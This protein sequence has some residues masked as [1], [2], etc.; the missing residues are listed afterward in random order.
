MLTVF[1]LVTADAYAVDGVEKAEL[2]INGCSYSFPI[3]GSERKLDILLIKKA[4]NGD[5]ESREMLL[6]GKEERLFY[7][8]DDFP[9]WLHIYPDGKM[10]VTIP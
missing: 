3:G 10:D 7:I 5:V 6:N 8:G 9:V 4:L 1:L 2:V